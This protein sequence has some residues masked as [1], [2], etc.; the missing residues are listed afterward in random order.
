MLC[1]V[2]GRNGRIRRPRT[3]DPHKSEMCLRSCAQRMDPGI[4]RGGTNSGAAEVEKQLG[5]AEAGYGW[6]FAHRGDIGDL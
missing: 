2:D 6:G 1:E 4:F 5:G 3:H